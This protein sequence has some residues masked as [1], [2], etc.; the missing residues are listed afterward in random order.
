MCARLGDTISN[1]E[2]ATAR[3]NKFNRA[4]RD[5]IAAKAVTMVILGDKGDGLP[6]DRAAAK[7]RF[8]WANDEHVTDIIHKHAANNGTNVCYESKVYT[9]V[10]KSI[11][12]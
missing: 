9:P 11:N 8:A 1:S 6:C 4:C 3:H 10:K 7:Q 12:L 5:A 2:S